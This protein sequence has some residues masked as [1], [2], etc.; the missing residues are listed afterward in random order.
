[1]SRL[2]E[3]GGVPGAICFRYPYL[4]LGD[5]LIRCF[6]ALLNVDWTR[7]MVH[8]AIVACLRTTRFTFLR[9]RSGLPIT[10]KKDKSNRLLLTTTGPLRD[11]YQTP[12][13]GNQILL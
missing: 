5:P 11:V 12:S 6:K 7:V 1:M 13:L 2:Q 3:E 4:I 10:T 8:C 9:G